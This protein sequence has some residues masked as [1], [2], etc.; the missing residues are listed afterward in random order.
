MGL[1]RPAWQSENEEKALRAVEKA[2]S[3]KKLARI[4][5][6]ATNSTVRRKAIDAISL[7]AILRMYDPA[8]CLE[9]LAGIVRSGI[10][11]TVRDYALGKLLYDCKGY[12]F[13]DE[14][15]SDDRIA[16]VVVGYS[17]NHGM[18]SDT[19]HKYKEVMKLFDKLPGPFRVSIYGTACEQLSAEYRE[20]FDKTSSVDPQAAREKA[21]WIAVRKA[22][23]LKINS[24][25]REPS[26]PPEIEEQ[27]DRPNKKAACDNRYE[28][29]DSE[30][31]QTDSGSFLNRVTK[32]CTRCGDIQVYEKYD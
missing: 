7:G 2:G 30:I 28:F 31:R 32:R 23:I 25:V 10:P 12:R 14:F 17:L 22:M 11:G 21:N 24:I 8:R 29:V 6:T 26:W 16:S 4:A 20:R 27:L 19:E 1:F 9:T 3:L 18:L 5:Q 15:I 13:I